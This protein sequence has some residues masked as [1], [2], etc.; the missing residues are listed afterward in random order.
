MLQEEQKD[1]E[2]LHIVKELTSE[3]SKQTINFS[4]K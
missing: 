3:I 1:P 2:L 4:S